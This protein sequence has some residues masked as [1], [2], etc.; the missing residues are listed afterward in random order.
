MTN[1]LDAAPRSIVWT[2]RRARGPRIGSD[3]QRLDL[4]DVDAETWDRIIAV[5]ATGM[6]DAGQA[7]SRQMAAE[8]AYRHGDDDFR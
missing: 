7:A 4:L 5:N 1:A 3:S 8:A 6:L 2:L